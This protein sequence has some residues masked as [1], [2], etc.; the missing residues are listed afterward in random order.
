M[1]NE[2]KTE[3][4]SVNMNTYT[5]AYSDILVDNGFSN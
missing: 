4:V 5:L 2:T 1:E 3:R